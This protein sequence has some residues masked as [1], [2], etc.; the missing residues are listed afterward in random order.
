MGEHA[1]HTI[2][3]AAATQRAQI[4]CLTSIT[5]L[6]HAPTLPSTLKGWSCLHAPT[7]TPTYPEGG[8]VQRRAAR[9]ALRRMHVRLGGQPPHAL[10]A[11]VHCILA[12]ARAGF[13]YLCSLPFLPPSRSVRAACRGERRCG[14]NVGGAGLAGIRAAKS[15]KLAKGGGEVGEENVLVAR[16]EMDISGRR[17]VAMSRLRSRLWRR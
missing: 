8:L 14:R 15:K 2:T 11:A 17:A 10:Q 13:S 7:P 4:V 3:R 9:G 5:P 12:E 16:I 1:V 6:P